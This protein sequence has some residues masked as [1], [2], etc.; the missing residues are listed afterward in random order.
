MSSS[1]AVAAAR[2]RRAGDNNNKVLKPSQVRN[3]KPPVAHTNMASSS[4][5]E[6]ASTSASNTSGA[7]GKL[8]VSDAFGLVTLRL[9]RVES[10]LQNIDVE[11]IASNVQNSDGGAVNGNSAL[12]RTLISRIEEVEHRGHDSDVVAEQQDIIHDLEEKVVRM[13]TELDD[14]KKM[15]YK[16]QSMV[17]D[18]THDVKTLSSVPPPPIPSVPS[19]LQEDTPE[20]EKESVAEETIVEEEHQ[21]PENVPESDEDKGDNQENNGG[22]AVIVDQQDSSSS[23]VSENAEGNVGAEITSTPTQD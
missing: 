16:L 13:E 3:V 18:V 14:T 4:L 20:E 7:N 23:K 21:V 17:I 19:S 1:R 22:E 8:S 6:N 12:I 2:A 10:I 11:E 9:G 15:L 5:H